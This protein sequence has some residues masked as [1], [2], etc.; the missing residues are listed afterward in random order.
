MSYFFRIL[1]SVQ[2]HINSPTSTRFAAFLQFLWQP[3]G[4][5]FFSRLK[6]AI[7]KRVSNQCISRR[8]R[9]CKWASRKNVTLN[10]AKTP[11]LLLD[12]LDN[13]DAHCTGFFEAHESKTAHATMGIRNPALAA[14]DSLRKQQTVYLPTGLPS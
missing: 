7:L 13:A 8:I 11:R 6:S 2:I 10:A 12:L 4:Y 5:N 1:L 9:S 14:F 3:L